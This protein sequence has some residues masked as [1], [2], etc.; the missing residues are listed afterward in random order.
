M[1]NLLLIIQATGEQPNPWVSFAPFVL[2]IIVFYFFMIRPQMKR[3]KDI[4]K[5]RNELQE[6]AKV[7]TISG[8][9]GKITKVEATTVILEIAP[10]VRITVEKSGVVNNAENMPQQR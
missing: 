5:F 2:L 4:N 9:H 8:I 3:Q 10:N 6:G 1:S 7:M